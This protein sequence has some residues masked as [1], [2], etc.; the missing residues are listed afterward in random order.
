MLTYMQ[1]IIDRMD[2][3]G[4]AAPVTVETS[5]I[6]AARRINLVWFSGLLLSL[7]AGLVGILGKQWLRE[8]LT[9][10]LT[11]PRDAVRLRQFR[12][13]GLLRWRVS[14]IIAMLPLLLQASLV[15]FIIGLLDLLWSIIEDRLIAVFASAI[16]GVSFVLIFTSVLLPLFF[17]ACP[18]KS[19][20]AL[21]IQALLLLVKGTFTQGF[22]H[23]KFSDYTQSLHHGWYD[24]DASYVMQRPEQSLASLEHSALIWAYRA[25]VSDSFQD[26]LAP[27]V[28]ELPSKMRVQFVQALLCQHAGLLPTDLMRRVRDGPQGANAALHRGLLRAGHNANARMLALLLDILPDAVPISHKSTTELTR[29]DLLN[30][31]HPLLHAFVWTG[32]QQYSTRSIL[33]RRV[34]DSLL[35]LLGYQG[36]PSDVVTGIFGILLSFDNL[37]WKLVTLE[38]VFFAFPKGGQPVDRYP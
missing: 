21:Q 30:I 38:G 32:K 11:A 24:A 19:P 20:L 26:T 5:I 8:Y 17:P 31:I 33:I 1:A 27:C 3:P 35:D 22:Q 13:G 16:V 2:N 37:F 34:Y 10:R 6:P 23:I 29:S 12:Y 28:Y 25:V 7:I 14:D 18:Y 4:I 15:L 36:Q 9:Q